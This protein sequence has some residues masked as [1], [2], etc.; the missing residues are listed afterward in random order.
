METK[1]ITN[2]EVVEEKVEET[3]NDAVEETTDVNSGSRRN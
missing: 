2:S 3:A 1:E